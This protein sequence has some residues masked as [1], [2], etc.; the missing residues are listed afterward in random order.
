MF[1]ICDA[2]LKYL[3]SSINSSKKGIVA[4]LRT[5]EVVDEW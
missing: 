4:Y 2:F 5:S 3:I 1:Q